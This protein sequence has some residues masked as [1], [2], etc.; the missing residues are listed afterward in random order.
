MISTQ[1]LLLVGAAALCCCLAQAAPSSASSI[2]IPEITT[3]PFRGLPTSNVTELSTLDEALR[4]L[5]TDTDVF[6]VYV[7]DSLDVNSWRTAP[8]VADAASLLVGFVDVVAVDVRNTN[9]TF[10]LSAWNVQ[11]VPTLFLLPSHMTY[12]SGLGAGLQGVGGL[13]RPSEY[14]EQDLHAETIKGWALK[15]LPSNLVEKLDDSKLQALLTGIEQARSSIVLIFSDKESTSPLLRRLALKFAQR[16][17]F[18]EVNGKRSPKLAKHFKVDAFPTLLL[19]PSGGKR[20]KYTGP[21]KVTDISA[22]FAPHAISMEQR[23]QQRRE[24]ETAAMRREQRRLSEDVLEIVSSSDWTSDVLSRQSLVGVL[25]SASPPASEEAQADLTEKLQALSEARRRSSVV[26]QYFLVRVDND[27]RAKLLSLLGGPAED[28]SPV[29]VFLHPSKGLFTRFTGAVSADPVMQFVS[30]KLRSGMP[31]A[32]S[33][34][35]E[36]LANF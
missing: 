18:A 34:V 17:A 31:G 35:L 6:V 24:A 4:I 29:L 14:A 33:I 23:E 11:V 9:L 32:K 21:L 36:K 30:S 12:R 10:L 26:S 5:R 16:I 8:T 27:S 25:F 7:Y 2:Q 22:F 15:G 19:F 13:K 3:L 1:L 20:I 28:G